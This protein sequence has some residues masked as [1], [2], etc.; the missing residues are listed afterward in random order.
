[1]LLPRL[2]REHEGAPSV[3]VHGLADD[4]SRHAPD[5]VVPRREEAVVRAAVGLPVPGRLPLADRH[6]AAVRS[7]RL[8]DAER[9]RVDVRDRE[10]TRVRRS[11]GQIGRL[12]EAAE[13]VRLLEDHGGRIPRRLCELVRVRDAAP[14][15]HLHDL[16]PEARRIRLHDLA[17]LRVDCLREHDLPPIGDVPRD[18]AGIRRDRGAVVS[19]RIRHVHPGELADDRLVLEDRLEDALAH[20][21]LV[22]R[23]RRQEL[24]P[25]ED[26][27][28]DRRHVVVVDPGAEERELLGG[29]DVAARELLDVADELRLAERGRQVELAVEPHALRDLL[30]EL[31][32]G[33]D[34]DGGEHLLAVGVG[35]RQ[36]PHELAHCSATC[37]L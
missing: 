36:I 2:E 34:A 32:H 25:R 1:M 35:E 27:V 23:V 21:W 22:R 28:G 26:D 24:A 33:G 14:V 3:D 31:V 15:R 20:L 10:R 8:E 6:G 11:L 17:H 16:E 13:E 30:E 4:T 7:R 9:H 37:A 29:R 5:E 19:G 12:L 18:E